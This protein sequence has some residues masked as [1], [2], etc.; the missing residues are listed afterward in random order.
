MSSRDNLS[1]GLKPLNTRDSANLYCLYKEKSR[2]ALSCF[3]RD[4]EE[5]INIEKLEKLRNYL[6]SLDCTE[7]INGVLLTKWGEYF[8]QILQSPRDVYREIF[9]ITVSEKEIEELEAKVYKR[10]EESDEEI[11]GFAERVCNLGKG[12]KS[13]ESSTDDNLH[14]LLLTMS[15]LKALED[16][17]SYEE[18]AENY[19][20]DFP[21]QFKINHQEIKNQQ[22][23]SMIAIVWGDYKNKDS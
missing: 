21:S 2:N 14:E 9:G 4:I 20:D 11:T 18:E 7:D 16:L 22:L 23:E 10:L 15:M 6:K 17:Y 13:S 19:V 3:I 5:K 1:G 8:L 12:S